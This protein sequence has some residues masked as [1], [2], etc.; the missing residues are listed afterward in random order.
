V[1]TVIRLVVSHIVLPL[2]PAGQTADALAGLVLLL[3]EASGRR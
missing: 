1:D 3:L 2:R